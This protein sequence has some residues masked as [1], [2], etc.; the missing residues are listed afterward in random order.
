MRFRVSA[1]A[2]VVCACAMAVDLPAR[3]SGPTA[4]VVTASRLA[5]PGRVD[6]NNPMVWFDEGAAAV[7]TAL[8]SWGGV[9]TV[10]RGPSVDALQL[11]GD[12]VFTSHPGHGVWFE[13][14]VPDADGRWYGFYH[15]E[16]PADDCGRP[17]RQLPRIGL[18]RSTDHGATW[19]DLGIV[20]DA[21][22]DTAACDSANRFVLGGVGDVSAVLDHASQDLFLYF[23]QYQRAPTLQ[24]VAVARLAWADRDAPAGKVTI[25]NDGAWLPVQWLPS[26][27]ETPDSGRW[28]Y[29]AGTPLVAPS[30]PFHDGQSAADVFWGP[31]IHWNTYLEQYV[32]LLNRAKDEQFGQDGIYVAFAPTLADPGAWSAP[33]RVLSGGGWYPQVAGP[34][35]GAGTDRLA[36]QRARLFLTGVSTHTL[37]FER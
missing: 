23:S 10:A 24:G 20:L 18:A 32:M 8:S 26:S 7:L 16:R 13:A 1:I 3:Q 22:P 12:A 35:V 37:E 6:S 36:G 2:W 25:W 4:R 11:A 5:L 33:I 31:S 19:E 28:S 17:E 30:L 9:P 15:H 27:E 21:P 34:E 29:P 14:V